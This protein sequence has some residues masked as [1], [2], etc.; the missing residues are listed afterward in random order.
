LAQL[1]LRREL[2]YSQ[3]QFVARCLHRALGLVEFHDE[4]R[5]VFG[6]GGQ[7]IVAGK[8]YALGA[9]CAS[10][11]AH[12]GVERRDPSQYEP[13]DSPPNEARD[14][15][16]DCE[17]DQTQMS[18][19]LQRR[20]QGRPW[21]S[22]AHLSDRLALQSEQGA[23]DIDAV[24]SR[25]SHLLG[26]TSAGSRDNGEVELSALR[27]AADRCIAQKAAHQE[28]PFGRAALR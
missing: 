26:R 24:S 27:H 1:D 22:N 17:R 4:L 14:A 5:H 11:S 13:I 2:N 20:L 28:G 18:E 9:A 10:Y 12:G 19:R 3:L 25:E 16:N 6:K 8:F 21:H 7:L 15:E 23:H